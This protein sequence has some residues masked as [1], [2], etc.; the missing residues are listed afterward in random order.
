FRVREHG[1]AIKI[2]ADLPIA[3]MTQIGSELRRV[4]LVLGV[5]LRDDVDLAALQRSAF[6]Q[7]RDVDKPYRTG[8]DTRSFRE[9]RPHCAR[10]IPGW[11]ANAAAVKVPRSGNAGTLEPIE[12]LRGIAREA[13]DGDDVG[14]LSDGNH[15]RRKVGYCDR[16][17]AGSHRLRRRRRTFAELNSQ[18]E[19]SLLVPSAL[20]GKIHGRGA[21]VGYPVKQQSDALCCIGSQPGAQSES[22]H[23]CYE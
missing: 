16:Y 19:S 20:F 14:A 7:R 3:R 23:G 2:Q 8:I 1:L 18:V 6:C 17:R 21:G 11:I 10:G 12:S 4:Q 22:Y 9:G 13:H 15:C 5:K